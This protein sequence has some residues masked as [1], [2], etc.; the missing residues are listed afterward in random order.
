[1]AEYFYHT[2]MIWTTGAQNSPQQSL[3]TFIQKRIEC[4]VVENTF[5]AH[6]PPLA[7]T[8]HHNLQFHGNFYSF[9]LIYI[10]HKMV[11]SSLLLKPFSI[12][13]YALDE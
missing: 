1:M 9:F 11:L 4:S 6:L 8:F 13:V 2:E 3:D 12:G 10:V 5:Q 7:Q